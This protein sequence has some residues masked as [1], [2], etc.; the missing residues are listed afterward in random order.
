MVSRCPSLE[1]DCCCCGAS[2][3]AVDEH[4]CIHTSYVVGACCTGLTHPPQ[5]R[6]KHCHFNAFQHDIQ[7][8]PYMHHADAVEFA[9]TCACE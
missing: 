5:T 1:R 6:T 2:V 3:A 8:H 9:V 7:C 4:M